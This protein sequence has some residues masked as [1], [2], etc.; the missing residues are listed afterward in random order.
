MRASSRGGK[1]DEFNF[2]PYKKKRHVGWHEIFLNMLMEDIWGN[3]EDIHRAIFYNCSKTINRN[4]LILADLPSRVDLQNQIDKTYETEYLKKMWSR[5]FRGRQL[6]KAKAFL[7]LQM[8]FV[9]FGSDAV[10]TDKLYDNGN[11]SEF[12]K[13]FPVT[14]ERQW[15]FIT[16]FGV[17]PSL[18]SM[19]Q[20]IREIFKQSSP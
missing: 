20:K 16:C 19:K 1:T 9:V 12:F 2:F 15:A 5:A 17:N 8:L 4:W 3:I 18:Q 14:D 10:L 6:S 7:K 13:K 11:L